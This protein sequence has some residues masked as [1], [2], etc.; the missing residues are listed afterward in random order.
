M[1]PI[2]VHRITLPLV[3]LGLFF[4][5]AEH[6]PVHAQAWEK[7][8]T[9]PGGDPGFQFNITDAVIHV[10]AG[11]LYVAIDDA[12]N[13][14]DVFRLEAS[15]NWDNIGTLPDANS[16][17]ILGGRGLT[18]HQ[19]DLYAVVRD[20]NE[21]GLKVYRFDGVNNWTLLG[22]DTIACDTSGSAFFNCTNPGAVT[23]FV[24]MNGNLYVG[25]GVTT[26]SEAWVY[27]W[28]GTEWEAIGNA[29]PLE[30]PAG[31]L[32]TS[33][34]VDL[35]VDG[36][37]LYAGSSYLTGFPPT[38][39]VALYEY[40]GTP[41]NWTQVARD[42]N[43]FPG[44]VTNAR[45][46]V[47]Y[48]DDIYI[49][50]AGDTYEYIPG[51]ATLQVVGQTGYGIG[52][53]GLNACNDYLYSTMDFQGSPPHIEVWRI[54]MTDSLATWQQVGGDFGEGLIWHGAHSIVSLDERIYVLGLKLENGNEDWAV[55]FEYTGEE[56]ECVPP[57]A[58][59]IEGYVWNDN[60][61]NQSV[62][63][64]ETNQSGVQV[65]VTGPDNPPAVFTDSTAQPN[66]NY[67]FT[68]LSAGTYT[69]D[70]SPAFGWATTTT[71]PVQVEITDSISYTANFGIVETGAVEGYVWED[72]ADCVKNAGEANYIADT[73]QFSMT[74]SGTP[75]FNYNF[76]S[77]G[78]SSGNNF[79]WSQI[80]PGTYTMNITST[81]P[82]TPSG[83]PG[84]RAT[85]ASD[86]TFFITPGNTTTTPVA[87]CIL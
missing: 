27:E 28:D 81:W 85:T 59:T 86:T 13:D 18:T 41:F 3:I 84:Y 80:M 69:V 22:D 55:V 73:V 75:S 49:Q 56:G 54:D 70:V 52:K 38:R 50:S 65:T 53:N 4:V 45:K 51:N 17:T 29:T 76:S 31:G 79:S 14:V 43:T 48:D 57:V 15:G 7:V 58:G 83:S 64:G 19:N 37:N 2:T 12:T 26:P 30:Q 40:D 20:R 68:G 71:D 16:S 25:T 74:R 66:P 23:G 10:H 62:N 60:D 47:L 61:L 35:I 33:G 6:S 5:S 72:N 39:Y 9:Y 63:G 21:D 8:G 46:M 82:P 87:T 42:N 77:T 32:A 78:S 34:N 36:G 24:G 11:Q 44:T 67:S 1:L